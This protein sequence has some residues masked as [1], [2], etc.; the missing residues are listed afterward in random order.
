MLVIFP[1]LSL[2]VLAQPSQNAL[3]EQLQAQAQDQAQSSRV[4][5][6][7][8]TGLF[9]Q[10]LSEETGMRKLVRALHQ[11][12][13]FNKLDF[14]TQIFS[15]DSRNNAIKYLDELGLN[16]S[17]K[18]IVIGH[19][20]GG[21]TAILLANE[22]K[23]RTRRVDLLIQIDSVGSSDDVLPGNV[24]RGINYYQS[25]DNPI[26][27][28]RFEVQQ[29]VIGSTNID[30]NREFKSALTSGNDYP[31]THGSIDDSIVIHKAVIQQIFKTVVAV[32]QPT[33]QVGCQATADKVLQEIRAKGVKRVWYKTY[34]DTANEGRAGNPTNRAD[35]LLFMLDPFYSP[36]ARGP[37]LQSQG[38]LITRILESNAPKDWSDKIVSNCNNTAIVSFRFGGSD[39]IMDFYIQS[40]GKAKRNKCANPKDSRPF[41]WGVSICL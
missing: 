35:V 19:S 6:V 40:D 1:I 38:N 4:I 34:K 33:H 30:V 23:Q 21:D 36:Q 13:E 11:E 20:Y 25:D 41:L 5:V 3:S 18:L 22:L 39:G 27:L 7:L 8:F 32:Q 12:T 31:V 16:K 29:K 15:W 2:C 37:S 28:G 17:D 24:T 14:K 9:S 26:S 10:T